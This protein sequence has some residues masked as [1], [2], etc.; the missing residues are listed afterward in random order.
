MAGQNVKFGGI[1]AGDRAAD[2]DAGFVAADQFAKRVGEVVTDP[3]FCGHKTA[4]I[5]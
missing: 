1:F 4:I 2:F 3:P 5:G